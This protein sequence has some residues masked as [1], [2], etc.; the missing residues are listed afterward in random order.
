MH[1]EIEFFDRFILLSINLFQNS[2]SVVI[3]SYAHYECST[4]LSVMG[5]VQ[6]RTTKN[7]MKKIEHQHTS[8]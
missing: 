4:D 5:I 6:N 2:G 7:V 1:Y 3:I 8:R